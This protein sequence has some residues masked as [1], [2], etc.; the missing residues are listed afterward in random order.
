M[1][2]RVYLQWTIEN[3]ITVVLMAASFMFVV[4]L[5]SSAVRHYTGT[6]QLASP[7]TGTSAEGY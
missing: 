6:A 3:W 5:V 4:G 1:A 7:N 2:E